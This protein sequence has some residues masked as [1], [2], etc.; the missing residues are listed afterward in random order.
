MQHGGLTVARASTEA[1]S[2][3]ELLRAVRAG[4]LEVFEVLWN[5]Y[6]GQ[7][8]GYAAKR[9]PIQQA[10]DSL[11]SVME[12]TLRALIAGKGPEQFFRAYVFQ[13][14]RR[15]IGR[16]RAE[17]EQ[18]QPVEH[19]QLDLVAPVRHEP[20]RL[21]VGMLV[22]A[23][24][25]SFS[26]SD[27]LLLTLNLEE[28]RRIA[29][30]ASSLG[31]APESASQRLYRA[32]NEFKSRWFAAHLDLADAPELC[33]LTLA[34]APY[35]MGRRRKP[36]RAK[37]F[38]SHVD[39]CAFCASRVREAQGAADRLVVLFPAAFAAFAWAEPGA[40]VVQ[41]LQPTGQSLNPAGLAALSDKVAAAPTGAKVGV[42]VGV[43]ALG[44]GG[45][46]LMGGLLAPPL[47]PTA[48]SLAPPLSSAPTRGNTAEPAIPSVAAP[49]R[50]PE[51]TTDDAVA[52]PTR[53]EAGSQSA[54]RTPLAT[55][56]VP[57]TRPA[58]ATRTPQAS[59]PAPVTTPSSTPK[60][61][62]PTDVPAPSTSA[63]VT[64]PPTQSSQA[65]TPAPKPAPAPPTGRK[66]CSWADGISCYHH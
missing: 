61:A 42:G 3:R 29:E 39:G 45:S 44:V 49:T 6:H 13:S 62:V 59:K 15:E 5:R 30:I 26:A 8:L 40:L 48:A 63:P 21:E 55:R 36:G 51:P 10:E 7:L 4:D 20:Q 65:S 25:G 37:K 16:Q 53:S 17:A 33:R 14:L 41:A 47:S 18:S 52:S 12:G 57:A 43:V 66:Q 50:S 58:P 35:A 64:V 31:L 2:D 34:D 11:S 60:S 1:V 19:E 32:K 22:E 46:L 54:A 38:W 9:L 23:I 24:L 27:R 28:G 56:S